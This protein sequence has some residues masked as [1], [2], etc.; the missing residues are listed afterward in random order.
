[1]TDTDEN[2]HGAIVLLGLSSDSNLK[3]NLSYNR[4]RLRVS[5][6]HTCSNIKTS[7]SIHMLSIQINTKSLKF[8]SLTT[9]NCP[10]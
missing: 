2:E 10:F 6:N 1:M 3:S 5:N 7:Q 4:L 8:L 9:S